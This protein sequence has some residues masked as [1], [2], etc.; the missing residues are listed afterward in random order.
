MFHCLCTFLFSQCFKVY[1]PLQ[2]PNRVS[3]YI[4]QALNTKNFPEETKKEM[5][6]LVNEKR[7]GY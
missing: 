6:S 4:K 5:T 2:D 7:N 1:L 3:L